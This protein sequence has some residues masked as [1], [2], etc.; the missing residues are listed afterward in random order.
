MTHICGCFG[1]HKE[2]KDFITTDRHNDIANHSISLPIYRLSTYLR[3]FLVPS[4]LSLDLE[5]LL[6]PSDSVFRETITSARSLRKRIG[7]S[8]II[9]S[10]FGPPISVL[11][12]FANMAHLPEVFIQL[13]SAN[14][15]I[16]RTYMEESS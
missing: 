14:K 12:Q 6:D 4:T 8:R 11:K 10:Q 1:K 13:D 3:G 9:A 15:M 16:V 7:F 5:C 2:Y